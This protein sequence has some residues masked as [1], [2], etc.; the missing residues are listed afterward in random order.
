MKV[1]KTEIGILQMKV[2]GKVRSRDD[3][4]IDNWWMKT[5]EGGE[6]SSSD[7]ILFSHTFTLNEY[8]SLKSKFLTSQLVYLLPNICRFRNFRWVR[9]AK[10]LDV[11]MVAH[12]QTNV[13]RVPTK[14]EGTPEERR[15]KDI[16]LADELVEVLVEKQD[17]RAHQSRI[18]VAHFTL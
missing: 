2:S 15:P 5:E 3:T 8:N 17:Q 10:Q 18:K 1:F 16:I 4:R 14:I 6:T 9:D 11:K 12:L 13:H 7:G